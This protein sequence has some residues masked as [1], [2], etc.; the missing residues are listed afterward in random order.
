M[1]AV[2]WPDVLAKLDIEFLF[3]KL[4]LNFYPICEFQFILTKN[5]TSYAT[6]ITGV[7]NPPPPLLVSVGHISPFVGLAPLQPPFALKITH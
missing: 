5:P 6:E 3:E 1:M 2:R 4:D 7:R